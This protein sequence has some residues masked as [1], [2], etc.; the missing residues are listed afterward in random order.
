MREFD[1][2]AGAARRSRV[3]YGVL[4]MLLVATVLNYVDR[5]ALGE[6]AANAFKDTRM[7][8]LQTFSEVFGIKELDDQTPDTDTVVH[9]ATV[10]GLVQRVLNAGENQPVPQPDRPAGRPKP[11][12]H[13]G[14][15]R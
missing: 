5:S 9:I 6:Q 8:S 15:R 3:R 7:E 10:Q 1:A 4:S 12:S 13:C 11:K 14:S 2:H